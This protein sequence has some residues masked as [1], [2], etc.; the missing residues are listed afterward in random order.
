LGLALEGFF[1]V[2]DRFALLTDAQI[3]DFASR[4]LLGGDIIIAGDYSVFKD[5]LAKRFPNMT[6]D[7]IKATDL[8]LSK[9]SLR[10]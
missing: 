3:R 8:D 5:D 1:V 10:K 6:V 7:V 4:N 2:G 9:D